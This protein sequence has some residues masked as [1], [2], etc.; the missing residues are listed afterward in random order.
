M[1]TPKVIEKKHKIEAK[2][3]TFFSDSSA[4]FTTTLVRCDFG[5]GPLTSDGSSAPCFFAD[6]ELW[7]ILRRRDEQRSIEVKSEGGD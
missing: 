4:D 7:G 3:I 5:V 2:V 6:D 1:G